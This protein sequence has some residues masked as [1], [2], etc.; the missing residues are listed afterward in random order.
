[1]SRARTLYSYVHR[2]GALTVTRSALPQFARD[3]NLR[4]RDLESLIKRMTALG[5]VRAN[6]DKLRFAAI[7]DAPRIEVAA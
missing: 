3:L 1:M 5:Q 4:P 7:R 2:C 6:G